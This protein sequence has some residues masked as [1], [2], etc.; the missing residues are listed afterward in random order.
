MAK[1]LKHPTT[2]EIFPY[3]EAIAINSY[4]IPTEDA[5]DWEKSQTAP[6]PEKA[7]ETEPAKKGPFG[8]PV[9]TEG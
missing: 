1:Y 2:G 6:E 4:L 9:K 3:T 7:K 8:R 5:P